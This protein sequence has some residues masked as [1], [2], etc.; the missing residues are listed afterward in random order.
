M[1]AALG[2]LLKRA[3]T[4]PVSKDVLKAALPGAGLNLALGTLTGGPTEGLAYALG[5][6]ALNY[7]ALRA[8][9]KLAPGTQQQITNLATGKVTQGYA[10]SMVENVTNVAASIGSSQ[11]VNSMLYPQQKQAQ[12][13][14]QDFLAQQAQQVNPGLRP[15]AA[16]VN[17]EVVQRSVLNQLPLGQQNLAPNTMYQM[18]GIEHTPFHYPGLT[19][20]PELLEELQAGGMA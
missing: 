19:I 17:Q 13:A 5:D 8:A 11:L 15:Q 9:R 2:G 1:A 3:F 18:Q 16:Q 7:P 12:A 20:P 14:A 4:G 10:P 6:L